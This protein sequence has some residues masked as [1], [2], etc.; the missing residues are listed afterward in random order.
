MKIPFFTAFHVGIPLGIPTG[1]GFRN[2][3]PVSLDTKTIQISEMS[4]KHKDARRPMGQIGSAQPVADRKTDLTV[5]NPTAFLGRKNWHSSHFSWDWRKIELPIKNSLASP[6][7]YWQLV[8]HILNYICWLQPLHPHV[9][10]S[11]HDSVCSIK[12]WPE[13]GAHPA[14]WTHAWLG[15]CQG[16]LLSMHIPVRK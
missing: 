9:W 16:V 14:S 11:K 5:M 3:P 2:H 12:E 8:P 1:A 13:R 4:W 7:Y 15:Q 10:F 6:Q